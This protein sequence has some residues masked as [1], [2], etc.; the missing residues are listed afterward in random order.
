M[1]NLNVLIL[2]GGSGKRLWPISRFLYPKQF[3][4]LEGNKT[5]LQDTLERVSFIEDRN[6]GVICNDDHRFLAAEQI[7]RRH[8]ETKIFLEP[9]SRNTAPAITLYALSI[10]KDSNLLVLPADHYIQDKDVFVKAIEKAMIDADKG[11]MVTFGI[12]PTSAN[13]Q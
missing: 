10:N 6:I 5:M 1:K 9:F 4:A 2:A 3:L 11:K 7:K 13:T 8:S 12:E